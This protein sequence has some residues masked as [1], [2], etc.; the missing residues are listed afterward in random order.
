[1]RSKIS[2]FS[3]GLFLL[4]SIALIFVIKLYNKPHLDTKKT[5]ADFVFTT[6]NFI[7]EY[8]Q[9][10]ISA[11]KKYAE[12]VIQVKGEI[13]NISTLKGNGVVTLKFHDLESSIICYLLPE[14]NNKILKFKKGQ[15]TAIKGI[16][17]GY[18]LDIN[19][20]KCVFVE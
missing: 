8:L 1:M 17:K 10:E 20:V 9:D 6:Q 7:S 13:Y 4:V 16:C 3:I 14:E 15:F 11:D 12:K 18:L 2:K 5:K 19:M